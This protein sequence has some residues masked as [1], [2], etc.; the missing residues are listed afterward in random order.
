MEGSTEK[1]RFK[2]LKYSRWFWLGKWALGNQLWK[3]VLKALSRQVVECSVSR[4]VSACLPSLWLHR[5]QVSNVEC[6]LYLFS[7]ALLPAASQLSSGPGLASTKGGLSLGLE[8][9][10]LSLHCPLQ[11]L[12]QQKWKCI[13]PDECIWCRRLKEKILFIVKDQETKS[14]DA[15]YKW[16]WTTKEGRGGEETQ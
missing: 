1:F 13:H 9:P 14:G 7:P 6:T 2:T 8:P 11:D 10:C 5:A 16:W 3:A 15:L 4:C 12:H